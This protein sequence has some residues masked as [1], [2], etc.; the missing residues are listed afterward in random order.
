M[1]QYPL[2][3]EHI[4]EFNLSEGATVTLPKIDLQPRYGYW[5]VNST[6]PGAEVLLNGRSIGT[7]PLQ[8]ARIASGTHELQLRSPL[9]HDHKENFTVADGEEKNFNVA[10][11]QAFG[12]LSITSDPTG[13]T[14]FIE[15][16]E[17]GVTP[18]NNPLLASGNYH[19]RLSKELYFDTCDQ[20]IINDGEITEKFI[21]LSKNYGT[22]KVQASGAELFINDRKVGDNSHTVNLLPGS[23][24]LKATKDL[25]KDDEREVFVTL[26]QLEEVTLLSPKP[27]QGVLSITSEPFKAQGADIFI[28]GMKREE[29]TPT[30]FRLPIGVYNVTVSKPDF[31]ELTEEARISEDAELQLSFNLQT[32]KGSLQE[33]AH[34]L[35]K[36]KRI[37][38]YTSLAAVGAGAYFRYSTISLQN[39]YKTATTDATAIFDKM[40]RHD[41]YS[42]VSFGAAVPLG[43][44]WIVKAAQQSKTE[45]KIKTAL[46]PTHDG[47]VFGMVVD[48]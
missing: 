37:F 46:V 26:G 10:L 23:Y 29:K 47:V 13:V 9:Y 5:Q 35:K 15:D 2:Y 20:I 28:D 24:R 25:H 31:L 45:R 12:E 21:A 17:V 42:W 39:D 41:L 3:Y 19:I 33:K 4:E 34:Q 32:Y 16:K 30:S 48:F 38:G 6:P 11:K 36:G 1:L 18:F 22:L 8:R 14:I 7:T 43:V 44:I 40:E 27:R